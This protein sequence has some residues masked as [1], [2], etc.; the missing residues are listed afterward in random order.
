VGANRLSIAGLMT[1]VGVFALD[2]AV[3]VRVSTSGTELRARPSSSWSASCLSSTSLAS[4]C[5]SCS[6]QP[7]EDNDPVPAPRPCIGAPQD[8]QLPG[9]VWLVES[10]DSGVPN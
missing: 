4:P 6:G 9:S 8:R 1:I 7:C 3:L 2:F 5:F 10:P